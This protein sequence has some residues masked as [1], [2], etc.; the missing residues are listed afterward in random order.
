MT[1]EK[2]SRLM[3]KTMEE[4]GEALFPALH[5][6]ER[7]RILDDYGDKE[8]EY[9]QAHAAILYTG[10][11]ETLKAL[12][13]HCDLFIVSNSQDGY[14]PAFLHAHRLA[15]YFKDIEMSSRTGKD[16]GENIRLIIERNHC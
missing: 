14:V 2:V 6:A 15:Q 7:K 16:K 11:E 10:L 1:Q 13:E 5:E 12:S 8:V 3:G 4:I 9:L